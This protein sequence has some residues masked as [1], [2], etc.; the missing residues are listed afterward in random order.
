[1]IDLVTED[2]LN[3]IDIQSASGPVLIFKHS[4][5]CSISNMALNR[6][7]RDMERQNQTLP[8]VYYL[9]LL[10]Y[11]PLSNEI[12]LRYKIQH[13]SPQLLLIRNASCEYVSSHSAIELAE[14]LEKI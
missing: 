3:E 9:D 14:V 6:F 7:R 10:N 4:T 5:R 12:A 11:R 13:E 8:P 1:M 2:Q